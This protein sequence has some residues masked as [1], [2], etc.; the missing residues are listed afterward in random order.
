MS[1]PIGLGGEHRNDPPTH[2]NNQIPSNT[3][4]ASTLAIPSRPLPLK[5]VLQFRPP[6]LYKGKP[7]VYFT[8]REEEELASVCRLI[9]I[10]KFSHGRALIEDITGDFA[11]RFSMRGTVQIGHYNA[12]HIF[13]SFTDEDDFKN[14]YFRDNLIILVSPMRVWSALQRITSPIGTL[15]IVDKATDVK[16]RPNFSKVKVEVDLAVQLKESVWVGIKTADGVEGAGFSQKIEYD[17]VPGFCFN[18]RHQRHSNEQCLRQEDKESNDDGKK[19]VV[20]PI[21]P[22]TKTYDTRSGSVPNG[23]KVAMKIDQLANSI[24][25]PSGTKVDV[26]EVEENTKEPVIQEPLHESPKVI[27]DMTCGGS[28]SSTQKPAGVSKGKLEPLGIN[29]FVELRCE[30]VNA[31]KLGNNLKG[32]KYDQNQ[33]ESE[34]DSSEYESNH[35]EISDNEEEDEAYEECNLSDEDELIQAFDPKTTWHGPEGEDAIIKERNK[36]IMTGNLSPRRRKEKK[37]QKNKEVAKP[38]PGTRAKVKTNQT[39]GTSSIAFND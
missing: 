13:I 31:V 2:S 9:I 34:E 37:I 27:Q 24:G 20:V 38:S 15:L 36:L 33:H 19:K 1:Q 10:G 23:A 28:R 18:C 6:E 35:E 4:Y 14:I 22:T 32:G 5:P 39:D 30:E 16:S 29:L 25:E 12:K 11:T 7:A 21:V 8:P 17:Y 26:K 3:S